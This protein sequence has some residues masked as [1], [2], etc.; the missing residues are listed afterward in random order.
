MW[1]RLWHGVKMP[2]YA[3]QSGSLAWMGKGGGEVYL[4]RV[5]IHWVV[6]GEEV[7]AA[8]GSDKSVKGE[9]GEEGNRTE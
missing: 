1:P 9:R 8:V 3:L 6:G 4:W 7:D 5:H 2:F